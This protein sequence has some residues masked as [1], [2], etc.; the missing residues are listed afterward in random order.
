MAPGHINLKYNVFLLENETYSEVRVRRCRKTKLIDGSHI[1]AL[2]NAVTGMCH[3]PI[4]ALYKDCYWTCTCMHSS[5]S[6]AIMSNH[7]VRLRFVSSAIKE[8]WNLTQAWSTCHTAARLLQWKVKAGPALGMFEVFGRIG[9]P[10]LG[11]RQ[12]WHPLFSVTYLFSTSNE[13]W[14]H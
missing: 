2:L 10:I 3:R 6:Y 8:W 5:C 9:P 4:Q 13:R 1:T 14:R 11:G 7:C 12:F